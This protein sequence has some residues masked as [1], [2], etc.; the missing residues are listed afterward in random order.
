MVFDFRVHKRIA[1]AGV[2]ATVLFVCVLI[3]RIVACD[4]IVAALTD[5]RGGG[6]RDELQAA[7]RLFP[8]SARLNQKLAEAE[9]SDA[10]V[11]E[12]GNAT[13]LENPNLADARQHA[14]RAVELSPYNHNGWLILAS[15]DEALGDR[16]E[17]EQEIATA[18]QLAPSNADV[19]WRY[20]NLLLRRGKIAESA[21]AFRVAV[22]SNPSLLPAVL[23]LVWPTASG[24]ATAGQPS[25]DQS[26]RML[27]QARAVV[28]PGAQAQMQLA[29]FLARRADFQDAAQVFRGIDAQA[30]RA[31]SDT[32]LFLKALEN[33]GQ[34]ALAREL[35]AKM[36]TSSAGGDQSHATASN[37]AYPIIWNGGFESDIFTDAGPFEWSIGRTDYAKF[38]VDGGISRSGARS[39][40]IE[41]AGRDTTRLD[42]ELKQMIVVRRDAHY[43]LDCYVRAEGLVT[44]D[45]PR[46]AVT[47]DSGQLASSEAIPAGSY[48]WQPVIVDFAAAQHSGSLPGSQ[49]NRQGDSAEVALWV[50]LVR[51]PKYSY[52]EPMRGRLWLDD[53]S[54]T[55][56]RGQR[57]EARDRGSLLTVGH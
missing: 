43:R 56:A 14:R 54:V 49:T 41:F 31:S 53:F 25:A 6:A 16:S 20:A 24:S 23:E 30:L 52:D 19:N 8:N 1:R 55:E 37:Q 39:L 17:A 42:G 44:T 50:S 35:W 27:S 10:G 13:D 38:S 28:G 48:E 47:S 51:T 2:L 7:N 33:L 29:L 18:R 32:P 11:G 26:A 21:P 3:G 57:L 4:F 34:P 36:I 46:I 40:R 9:F 22:D 45:G 5:D 15:I 12:T